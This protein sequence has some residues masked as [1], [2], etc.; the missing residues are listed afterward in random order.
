MADLA[1]DALARRAAKRAG[2]LA[3][4]TRWRKGYVENRGGFQLLDDR[5]RIVAGEQFD[6][7][8][9]DVIEVCDGRGSGDGRSRL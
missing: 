9:E 2:L 6:L 7:T 5:N 1:M 8:A 4:K 3:R